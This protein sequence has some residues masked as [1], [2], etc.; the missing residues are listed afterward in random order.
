MLSASCWSPG[1]TEPAVTVLPR[2]DWRTYLLP[3]ALMALA[4]GGWTLLNGDFWLADA[5]YRAQGQHWA[6]R[7]EWWLQD[8]LHEGGRR[9]S[10]LAGVLTLAALIASC[11]HAR[12]QR[13]RKPLLYLFLAA[14]LSTGLVSLIKHLS[15]MDCPWALQR[16][17]GLRPFIGLFEA[18]P[19]DLGR[20]ACFPSGH[21]SAGYAWVALYFFALRVC[22]QWR[23]W[24][25]GAALL[26]GLVFGFAQ[27]LRGAHF[28]SHDITTLAISWCVAALLFAWMFRK[29]IRA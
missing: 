23:W 24:G 21:A 4:A 8:V 3:L 13:W 28:L 11:C 5:L 18:R 19:A 10:Q 14:G 22:P 9:F 15:H 27:Q 2:R 20:A 17:G 25:L 26:A 7:D 29:E 16:Y 6:L 12:W 1:G